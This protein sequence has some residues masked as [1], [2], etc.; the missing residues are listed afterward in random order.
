MRGLVIIAGVIAIAGGLLATIKVPNVRQSKQLLEMYRAEPAAMLERVAAAIFECAPQ[1]AEGA[2]GERYT[3]TFI[4]PFYIEAVEYRNSA[5]PIDG[6]AHMQKWMNENHAN[7][8]S[9][10]SEDDFADMLAL[11]ETIGVDDV[12]NCIL[13]SATSK[14]KKIDAKRWELRV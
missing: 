9:Q 10:I 13:S 12:E 2:L 8:F 14:P 5:Q 3:K 4:T 1:S 6:Q 11:I 7:L